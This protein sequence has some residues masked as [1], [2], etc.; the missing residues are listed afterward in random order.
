MWQRLRF[1]LSR[2]TSGLSL[3]V[4]RIGLGLVL[5]H[6]AIH[7]LWPRPGI[8]NYAAF[9]YS[10]AY[11]AW[12]FP[13]AGFEWVHPLPEPWLNVVFAVYAVA[14]VAM[15]AGLLTR[16]ASAT[17]FLTYTYIFLLDASRYNNHYYLTVLIT[18]IMIFAPTARCL[19]IDGLLAR[20]HSRRSAS[21]GTIPF[22]PIFLLRFQWL[23]VYFYGAVT[24]TTDAWLF[25]AQ[26]VRVW[27]YEPRVE[28]ALH[29][30]LP[31]ATVDVVLPM[32]RSTEMAFF[33]SWGGMLFDLL[34]VPLLIIRRTRLLGLVLALGFH[35]TN[36]WLLFDDIGW[37][38]VMAMA[39]ITIFLEP[40]WPRRVAVWLKHPVV[41]RPNWGWLTVG[42]VCLPP[43][44]ALLGW[45][46]A[47]S[48]QTGDTKPRPLAAFPVVI[49]CV[50][51]VVQSIV[52]LRHFFIPGNVDWTAEGA[53]FSWRMKA[54]LKQATRMEIVVEPH[55]TAND[56]PLNLDW[57]AI[58]QPQRIYRH[59]PAGAVDFGALPE[60]FVAFQPYYGER[61]IY[62]PFQTSAGS[63]RGWDEALRR[64]M[65]YW[66]TTYGRQPKVHKTFPLADVLKAV[67]DR[68][69]S[70]LM[71]PDQQQA[72]TTA[73]RLAVELASGS[74]TI[75]SRQALVG[76]LREQLF[77]LV[78]SSNQQLSDLVRR[79]VAQSHPFATEGA[80]LPPGPL[81]VVD[82]PELFISQSDSGY[83][84]LDREKWKLQPDS[85]DTVYAN[86]DW[87][88]H[89]QWMAFPLLVQRID[90]DG[91][92]RLI[93]NQY[94]DLNWHQTQIMVA[95]PFMCHQY[96]Q[97]IA[98][99]WEQRLGLRPRVY[100]HLEA[101]LLP[102][103]L[104]PVFDSHVDMAAAPLHALSHNEW[105]VHLRHVVA[106]DDS[107]ILP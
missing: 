65:T 50:W 78:A 62:N 95:R 58:G 14:A 13:Y 30:F 10:R 80:T 69:D 17:V 102:Y 99:W 49:I 93:W 66:Q 105:I 16:W 83:A 41:N 101:A 29:R 26:P 82:D 87:M 77:Q 103:T 75:G 55:S 1:F 22:W 76:S 4:F 59:V 3:A 90:P 53:R 21:D 35:S 85:I 72:L 20:R 100:M 73:Q 43:L 96:A 24:K 88:T 5:A 54:G 91:S 27:L 34:I 31:D 70:S 46:F 38:P 18:A 19:S 84:T 45:K 106:D 94:A 36:H 52:P 56:S 33:L 81:L 32:V 12:L 67:E 15:A 63:A 86:M 6:D 107:E 2:R 71:S 60:L 40:D 51:V 98:T 57:D 89:R 92:R 39:G 79:A 97:R 25:H 42:V 9:D 48:R 8:G 68:I 104:Q 11:N 23:M 28:S 37:F 47:P 64:V 44:G 61:V 74:K 7:Y